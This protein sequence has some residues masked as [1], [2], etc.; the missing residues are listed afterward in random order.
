MPTITLFDGTSLDVFLVTDIAAPNRQIHVYPVGRTLPELA[1]LFSDPLK[2]SRMTYRYPDMDGREQEQV[3]ENF[4]E[5]FL[6][7]QSPMTRQ[8]E[9]K[10]MVWLNPAQT[11]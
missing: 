11:L 8:P 10:F 6:I 1:A 5:L 9:S 7:Q 2:T 3:F 4:T